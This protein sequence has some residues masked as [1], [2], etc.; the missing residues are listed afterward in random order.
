[1]SEVKRVEIDHKGLPFFDDRGVYVFY[2]DYAALQQKL[3]A[4]L[5]ENVDLR[6][7]GKSA[8]QHWAAAD[9]GSME[10]LMDKCMPALRDACNFSPATDAI[11]NEVRAEG[12]IA[13]GVHLREWYDY[14]VESRAEDF[15]AQL[16][17]GS[18]EG[19]V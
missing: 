7:A 16:R 10:R 15:A 17:A 3:D 14:Q 8:V 1:M 18:T 4:V 6:D 12:A 13:C 5:A 2:E 9:T 11:L 19:G